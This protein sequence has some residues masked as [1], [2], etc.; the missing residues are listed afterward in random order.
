MELEIKS[1]YYGLLVPK[2]KRFLALLMDVQIRPETYECVWPN[3]PSSFEL[4]SSFNQETKYHK[5]TWK[6]PNVTDTA[7]F[8]L[9]FDKPNIYVLIRYW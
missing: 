9:I 5:I 6:L 3:A 2:L 4:S 1:R 7:I 8:N